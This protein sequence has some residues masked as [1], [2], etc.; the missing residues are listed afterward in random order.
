MN[1]MRRLNRL[2]RQILY[3][4][5]LHL[6]H[7]WCHARRAHSVQ[8]RINEEEWK[9]QHTTILLALG[10]LGVGFVVQVVRVRTKEAMLLLAPEQA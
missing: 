4:L 2:V 3:I 1:P 8:L 10:I 7:L 5:L 6:S 9:L